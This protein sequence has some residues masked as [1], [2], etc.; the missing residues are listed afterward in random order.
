[1][2]VSPQNSYFEILIPKGDGISRWGFWE[3]LNHDSGTLINGIST[4]D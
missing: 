2:F 3:V 4:L 1:M